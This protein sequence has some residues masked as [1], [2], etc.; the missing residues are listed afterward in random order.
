MYKDHILLV[1]RVV[2]I[3]KFHC[4]SSGII[5]CIN[6]I[7]ANIVVVVVVA[8]VLVLAEIL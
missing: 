4:S 6:D 8:V 2:L 1:P 5:C 3:Y 7:S